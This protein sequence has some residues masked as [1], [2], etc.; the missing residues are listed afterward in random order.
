MKMKESGGIYNAGFGYFNKVMISSGKGC[1]ID[2]NRGNLCPEDISA[3]WDKI[4]SMENSKGYKDIG[5]FIL[6]LLGMIEK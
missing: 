1:L 3:N 6:D 4:S 5:G 2:S